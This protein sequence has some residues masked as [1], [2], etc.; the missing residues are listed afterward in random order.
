MSVKSKANRRVFII[1]PGQHDE[2]TLH[3][4]ASTNQRDSLF[5]I[6]Q[7]DRY[8]EIDRVGDLKSAIRIAKRHGAKRPTVI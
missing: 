8:E 5:D 3:V 1:G 2:D 4:V 6:Y 7:T